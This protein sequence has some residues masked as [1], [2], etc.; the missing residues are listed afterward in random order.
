MLAAN[1][2][3]A[4]H[5]QERPGDRIE[6][7]LVRRCSAS[8]PRS[9]GSRISGSK[10]PNSASDRFIAAW[11]RPISSRA[12]RC[13]GPGSASPQRWPSASNTCGSQRSSVDQ[14]RLHEHAGDEAVEHHRVERLERLGNAGEQVVELGELGVA[15]VLGRG[16]QRRARRR[17]R[18]EQWPRRGAF[19]AGESRGDP[20]AHLRQLVRAGGARAARRGRRGGSSSPLQL[21]ASRSVTWSKRARSKS[22]PDQSMSS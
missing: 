3:P 14:L 11:R 5:G 10:P 7:R 9:S 16:G 8:R 19:S 2:K 12:R 4:T 6:R 21:A 22:R 15:Q 20:L 1:S 18:V 13:S 17:R